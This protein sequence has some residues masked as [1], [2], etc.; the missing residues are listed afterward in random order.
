MHGRTG[1]EVP[2]RRS[3][4]AF[5]V[6]A[7]TA[8]AAGAV[9]LP[10]GSEATVRPM[11]PLRYDALG[12]TAPPAP[13]A[14]ATSAAAPARPPTAATPAAPP[15]P[16]GPPVTV[17][18]VGDVHGEPPID[19]VLRAGDNPLD[20]V[21]PILAGADLAVVNVETAI[22]TIGTPADKEFTFRAHPL[23]ATA[24]G[25]AGVD[26]GTLANNHA[27]DYGVDA[28]VQT[29]DRLRMA[30]VAPVGFGADLEAAGA[31]HVVEVRG[32]TVAVVGLSRVLP[33]TAWAATADGP[34]AASAYDVEGAVAV[35]ARAAAVAD[36]VVVTVHWGRELEQC[37]GPEQIAL[38]DALVAAGADVVAGHH[39]HVLQGVER[40]DGALV[41]WSLGNFVFYARTPATRAS[42]VLVVELDGG[43]A[44][45]AVWHPAAI[46]ASGQPV[47]TGPSAGLEARTACGPPR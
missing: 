28:A 39:P 32:R 35:V 26:V 43:R 9:V 22:A 34:G 8:F 10:T 3:F 17:A 13:A 40:R 6:A 46:D 1:V 19:G 4:A 2:W 11:P 5:A 42:G 27:L 29:A 30:G 25:Q 38:A 24:L 20:A 47:P 15:S 41:A 21:T 44:L 45:D 33:T 18:L 16:A 12:A 7:A 31:A 14:P 37:P 23:L 36:H